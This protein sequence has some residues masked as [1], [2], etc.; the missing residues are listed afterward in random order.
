LNLSAEQIVQRRACTL[1][2]CA[3]R[4]GYLIEELDGKVV[5]PLMPAVP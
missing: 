2:A 3:I 5:V 1:R 4:S